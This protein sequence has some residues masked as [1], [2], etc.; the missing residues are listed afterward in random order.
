MFRAGVAPGALSLQRRQSPGSASGKGVTRSL[1]T[2]LLIGL[3]KTE[4]EGKLLAK[5]YAD[6]LR[7]V[8]YCCPIYVVTLW[9][10]AFL[11]CC[12]VAFSCM[13]PPN[14]RTLLVQNSRYLGSFY[15]VTSYRG[16]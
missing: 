5:A 16:T 2:Q 6:V 11:V 13:L 15:T 9:T 3:G 14:I 10:S 1:L 8:T 7:S 4:W 12:P